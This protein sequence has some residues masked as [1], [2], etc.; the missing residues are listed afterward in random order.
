MEASG[1]YSNTKLQVRQL[2]S[3]INKLP[4]LDGPVRPGSVQS[5][6]KRARRL[7]GDEVEQLIAGYQAGATVY[8]LGA[9]FEIERRTV[10]NILHRHGVPMRR[11]GL[12]PAQVDEAVRL[13]EGGWSLAR[14]G[15]QMDVD[16]GTV[17]TRLLERGVR[18]RDTHGR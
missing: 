15:K 17:R 7:A 12:S 14:I 3:L 4:G 18:M 13:Y 8:E 11:R 6:P 9:R 1:A 10:S 5:V 16:A 2:E